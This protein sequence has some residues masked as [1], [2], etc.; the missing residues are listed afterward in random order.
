MEKSIKKKKNLIGAELV[1]TGLITPEQLKFAL[2][3]QRKLKG[4]DKERLGEVIIR[5][6]FVKEEL[7]VPFL[8]KYL[9][10]P[11]INVKGKE[12]I[13]PRILRLIPE[14]MARNFK[15][16][17][18]D[19]VD[20]KLRVA[21]ANPFDVIAL[22]TIKGKTGYKI[23]RCFSH[24]PDIVDTIDK[25]YRG[26][27]FEKSIHEF[28]SLKAE[29]DEKEK[30]IK[31]PVRQEIDYKRLEM[32][33]AKVP[34]VEFVSQLLENAV[35]QGASDIHI[36]PREK[37]L[38]IRYRVDGIL[39]EAVPP[40]KQMESAILT[41]VKLLGRMDI[42]ERRLPQ[43]GR[44]NFETENKSIDVRLASTPTIF[45]EKLVLR[46][47]DKTSLLLEMKDLGFAENEV[48]Q[49]KH[50]LK[51]PYGMVLVTGPTGCGKTTTLYSA[52]NYINEPAKNIVTIEDP[53]EYQLEGINQIQIKPLIGLTF[54]S[55]LRTILRQDPDIIMI[56]EI[57]DLETLENAVKAA[58]TGHLVIST[59]HTNDAPSVV[60]RLVHMGLE[61]YLIVACLSMVLAQ[62]LIRRICAKCRQ[63][64]KLTESVIKGLEQRLDV[65][66]KN[67]SF[68]KGTGCKACD[69]TGYK[70]RVGIFELF[71]INEEIKKLILEGT[72]EKELKKIAMRFGMKTLLQS[73]LEKVDKGITS[74]E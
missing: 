60:Y 35:G 4:K 56:G 66:L 33:A 74:V 73:G 46:L 48:K 49:F 28:I 70:G 61:Q 30:E 45:G 20:G 64:I 63:K 19:I 54:A 62:R 5:C 39:R 41:R 47:L 67:I 8:E 27:N 25:F 26:G 12:H 44:F 51:Q 37:E 55:S 36:E 9:G 72:S 52:L 14:R 59:I 57:R 15:L 58:L 2:E 32:E 7:M 11:Y 18:I 31:R 50:V 17:G 69:R 22:D 6:G 24:P 13:D 42:A 29:E 38:F 43:D 40:P 71:V 53:V 3:E 65:D 21:M 23:Q 16:I 68:Y 34:V 10:I 1:K